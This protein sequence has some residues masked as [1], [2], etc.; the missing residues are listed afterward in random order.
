M[1]S[2][3]SSKRIQDPATITALIDKGLDVNVED[4]RMPSILAI[5]VVLLNR[6]DNDDEFEIQKEKLTALVNSGAKLTDREKK[7]SYLANAFNSLK[8]SE[9]QKQQINAALGL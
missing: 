8:I 4:G 1:I 9:E 5:S 3:L 7:K 2:S 6:V